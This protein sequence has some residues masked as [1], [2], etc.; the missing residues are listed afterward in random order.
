MIIENFVTYLERHF[1][2][3]IF[4]MVDNSSFFYIFLRD[5][6]CIGAMQL[7]PPNT[8]YIGC[9]VG[10]IKPLLRGFWKEGAALS[11]HSA[12]IPLGYAGGEVL[13]Q[14]LR[15]TVDTN[16]SKGLHTFWSVNFI[17]M[18]NLFL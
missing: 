8:S 3:F 11:L 16:C 6:D 10:V 4:R 7:F 5:Q 2:I 14:E 12:L 13:P 1:R 17:H 18:T 15:T 9:K